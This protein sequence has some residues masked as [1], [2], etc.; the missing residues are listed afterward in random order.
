SEKLDPVKKRVRSGAS[1]PDCGRW[2]V[3]VNPNCR[4]FHRD[5]SYVCLPRAE[6]HVEGPGAKGAY[7]RERKSRR[8]LWSVPGG[9]EVRGTAPEWA[10]CALA[11]APVPGALA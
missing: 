7:R 8:P 6:L 3:P 10:A 5:S 9:P 2:F 4:T 11:G 1:A